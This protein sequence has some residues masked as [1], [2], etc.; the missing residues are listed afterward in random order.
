MI[1]LDKKMNKALWHI[2]ASFELFCRLSNQFAKIEINEI[3]NIPFEMFSKIKGSYTR[4]KKLFLEGRKCFNNVYYSSKDSFA[5]INIINNKYFERSIVYLMDANNTFMM[6]KGNIQNKTIM[7]DII[8][9]L[10]ILIMQ[11]KS[12]ASLLR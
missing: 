6:A 11:L 10:N 1:S 12:V 2:N 4:A 7:M 5:S 8:S 9:E 3:N